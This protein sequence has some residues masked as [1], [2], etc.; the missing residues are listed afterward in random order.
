MSENN[1]KLFA[2]LTYLFPSLAF[3]SGSD[4][5]TLIGLEFVVFVIVLGSIFIGKLNQKAKGI[6]FIAYLVG[7]AIPWYITQ[8]WPY[9]DNL[10]KINTLCISIPLVFWITSYLVCSKKFG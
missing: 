2:C 9:T 4:I 5:L 10:F 8:D 1:L 7:A 3:A 6:V